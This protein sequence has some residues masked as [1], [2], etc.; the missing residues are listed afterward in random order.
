M[1]RG[2]TRARGGA[3]YRTRAS[4]SK[5]RAQPA[6]LSHRLVLNSWMLHLFEAPS[7]EALLDLVRD[8]ESGGID[9]EWIGEDGVSYFHQR[10]TVARQPRDR[11]SHDEL[12]RHDERI[13][14]HW[15]T[16]TEPPERRDLVLK[17][18][19][20]VALLFTEI[21][22]ERYFADAAALL[23]T[24]NEH[25]ET[26]N[27]GKEPQNQADPFALEDLNKLAF[28]MAT[29]SGK[30]LLMHVN[31]AQYLDHLERAGRR[32]ELNRIIL[33]TPNEGL[34]R[35]HLEEFALS[36][37]QA[38]LF[39]DDSRS[40]FSGHAV[41]VIHI[42]RLRERAGQKTVAVDA[43]EGNNLV[44]VDEGHRGSSSDTG[45][46]M[47]FRRRLCEAGFSFEYSATFGQAIKADSK[48]RTL[49]QE[50]GHCILF[51]YS[52]GYFHDDGYG[53]EFHVLNLQ[54]DQAG[55]PRQLYLTGCLLTFLQQLIVFREDA[56]QIRTY[57]VERPLWM[58]VGSTVA[59]ARTTPQ[60]TS[61]IVEIIR[62]FDD[63]LRDGS[64]AKERIRRLKSG[65]PGLTDSD[66]REIF[67]NR[68][69]ELFRD[70]EPD[71]IYALAVEHIFN[72]PNSGQLHIQQL[73][74]SSAVGE[75]EIRVADNPPFGVVNVGEAAKVINLCREQGLST[76]SGRE[77]GGS[78]F[79]HV[80]DPDSTVTVLIGAKKFTE[81][82]S[83][84]RVSTMGLLNVGVGEGAE[85]IQLFGRG[86]RLKGLGFSLKRSS[87]IR[88]DDGLE[89]P[90]RL[91]LLETLNV[92]GVRA[93]YMQTFSE[94]LDGERIR[95]DDAFED[96]TLRVINHLVSGGKFENV[97]LWTLGLA[98]EGKDFKR[99]APK[100]TLSS[101]VPENLKTHRVLVD[102]YP[103]IQSRFSK[104]LAAGAG[105]AV[106]KE[107]GVLKPD[108]LAFLD[109]DAIWFELQRY[110]SEK[111]LYN[112]AIPRE[113]P[114]ALL[115][116][117]GWYDLYIPPA[118]LDFN[119]Y[120]HVRTWHEVAV[121]LLKK[122]IERYYTLCKSDW[123]KDFL[124]L[125]RLD[126]TDT[127]LEVTYRIRVPQA[128]TDLLDEV[129][130]LEGEVA[131]GSVRPRSAGQLEVLNFD[132]HLYTP[133]LAI[134]G[135]E[136]TPVSL[137]KG[138]RDFVRHLEEY[139]REHAEALEGQ[140]IY[141][142]R[143]K[144]R[145]KG[146]GFFEAGNYY[147]D[148]ILWVKHAGSEHIAFV[149]PKGLRNLNGLTDPKIAL[150]KNIKAHQA[151]LQAEQPGITLDAFLVSETAKQDTQWAEAVTPEQFDEWH[152]LFPNED[153]AYIERLF[154]WIEGLPSAS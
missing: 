109:F 80:T 43:F 5:G 71:E 42:G 137:N 129:R 53:K 48:N 143:N 116:A 8:R 30:T 87:Y 24:L 54:D 41:E 14:R 97:H 125:D 104:G 36:G 115:E 25:V 152:V 10:L 138:E 76:G 85:V 111:S 89:H 63:F 9:R 122:Y 120:G 40:L 72:A 95:G 75:I 86:V 46:W 94:I 7:T 145:G 23:E 29:G 91:H 32:P 103:R 113:A 124:K 58:F 101:L 21:Y 96:F 132:G 133:L 123:E 13:V 83:S 105:S 77:F 112:L 140:E 49:L 3:T 4:S 114:R 51:D 99:S 2:R 126:A 38:D 52:Y 45:R 1:G 154:G 136:M 147:P 150:A 118:E 139:V 78:L 11:L 19:Q 33:L 16:L 17:H 73:R 128:K 27:F 31:I 151:R 35:Q 15:R 12:L 148:F 121:A 79:D 66:Q 127:N 130:T 146:I 28:W 108:H 134:N 84:W 26:W 117:G 90:R 44:L 106:H 141:L 37:I 100:P 18:F 102:W 20:Y 69:T 149:D 92:F 47:D 110:K 93:T 82:W 6:K 60:D 153:P 62:F 131:A 22:L 64:A 88:R 144:S 67:E 34:S 56:A 61:D 135:A 39:A 142:L 70:R 81:G 107:Q 68:L 119:D 57:G 74:D 55:E 65:K 50:Y 59:K 98:E